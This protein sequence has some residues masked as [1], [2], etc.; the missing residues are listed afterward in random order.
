MYIKEKR[1]IAMNSCN[2]PFIMKNI[3]DR[4]SLSK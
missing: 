2:S 1:I 4:K 3:L